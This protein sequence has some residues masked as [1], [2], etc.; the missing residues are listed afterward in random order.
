MLLLEQVPIPLDLKLPLVV[1][2][3]AP[4]YATPR[5]SVIL[6]NCEVDISEF[7]SYVLGEE[8]KERTRNFQLG[9]C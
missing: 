6:L 1:V 5:V 2:L 8:K 7:F 4:T 3:F 9:K